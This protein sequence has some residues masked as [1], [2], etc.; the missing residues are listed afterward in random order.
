MLKGG[1]L[2]E[3][4][5]LL[6]IESFYFVTVYLLHFNL[7]TS[8]I[9]GLSNK[10]VLESISYSII[11]NN[12]IF[13]S[14]SIVVSLVA[15]H[16]AIFFLREHRLQNSRWHRLHSLASLRNKMRL[17]IFRKVTLAYSW[18]TKC[19]ISPK[20]NRHCNVGQSSI[21]YQTTFPLV[22]GSGPRAHR[23]V[24]DS[25]SDYLHL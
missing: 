1:D 12:H 24:G 17:K 19:L 14:N 25:G 9:F 2:I 22:Q 18:F 4:K 20:D 21:R 23:R 8:T 7:S 5:I 15:F 13:L 10:N 6:C 11:F 3:N 16:L